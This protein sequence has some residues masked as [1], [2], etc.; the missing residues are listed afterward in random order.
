MRFRGQSDFAVFLRTG[1]RFRHQEGADVEVKFNPWHDPDDGRFTFAG[2][3]DFYPGGGGARGRGGFRRGVGGE[4]R[5]K[6]TAAPRTERVD[7]RGH[8]DDAKIAQDRYA[9]S[10]DNPENYTVYRVRRGDTLTKIARE[11]ISL[12][13]DELARLN[14]LKPNAKLQVGQQIRLPAQRALDRAHDEQAVFR[15]LS[16]YLDKHDGRL[17]PGLGRIDDQ[18][19]AERIVSVKNSY[20][21]VEDGLERTRLAE[22]ELQRDRSKPSKTNQRAAGGAD[23]RPTDEGG[24]Y[25]AR[26]FN[27][28]SNRVNLFAQDRNFNRGSYRVLEDKLAGYQDQGKR[29]YVRIIPHYRGISQRPYAIHYRWQVDGRWDRKWFFNE[30]E[31]KARD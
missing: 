13:A 16:R 4:G 15:G 30:K 31:G 3:G 9:G 2:Q 12:G 22:G 8:I 28:P 14:R 17:P 27:G 19:A 7:V 29:V 25:I 21:F 10:L 18:L 5:D 11:R 23:R 1:L 6:P 24:H 26:R 20:P